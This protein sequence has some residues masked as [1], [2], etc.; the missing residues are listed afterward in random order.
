MLPAISPKPVATLANDLFRTL[1]ELTLAAG[2]HYRA[3]SVTSN[4][5][6]PRETPFVPMDSFATLNYLIVGTVLIV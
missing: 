3:R 5:R 6:L 1:L 2:P 4:L